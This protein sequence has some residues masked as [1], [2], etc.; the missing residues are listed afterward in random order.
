[1]RQRFRSAS[2]FSMTELLFAIFVLT[3]AG[4][5]LAGVMSTWWKVSSRTQVRSNLLMNGGAVIE[6]VSRSIRGEMLA[7]ASIRHAS[8]DFSQALVF[9]ADTDG[10]GVAD[11]LKGWGIRPM[12]SSGDGTQ[13]RLDSDHDGVLDTE[14]W[15]L[16][17]VRSLGTNLASAAWTE[18]VR[19]RN[20]VSDWTSSDG[21]YDYRPFCYSGSDPALDLNSDGYVSESEIGNFVSKNGVID[22][23]GEVAKITTVHFG[24]KLAKRGLRKDLESVVLYQGTITPRNWLPQDRYIQSA[25]P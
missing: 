5:A 8:G 21:L 23:S 7:P 20:L 25:N 24:L 3:I 6:R 9:L 15:E 11:R 10:D 2:A 13:D 1:M 12:S 18:T 17:E 4:L 14:L 22:H 16:V 19:C